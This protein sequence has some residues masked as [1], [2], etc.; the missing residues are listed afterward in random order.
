MRPAYLTADISPG[1]CGSASLHSLVPWPWVPKHPCRA[2]GRELVPKP[3]LGASVSPLP[4]KNWDS[5]PWLAAAAWGWPGLEKGLEKCPQPCPPPSQA[6]LTSFLSLKPFPCNLTALGAF[7][8]RNL[9]GHPRPR[10][11]LS[12]RVPHAG[13]SCWELGRANGPGG[14]GKHG[15]PRWGLFHCSLTRPRAM[16]GIIDS[17]RQ[18]RRPPRPAGRMPPGTRRQLRALPVVQKRRNKIPG[19]LL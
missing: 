14:T 11:L 12:T 19:R 1:D 10:V 6:H 3:T 9:F 17:S 13:T 4:F 5:F 8:C 18:P 2:E 16:Q 7:S 15:E